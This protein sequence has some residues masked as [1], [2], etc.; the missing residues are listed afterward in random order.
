MKTA[1]K[2][3][4]IKSNTAQK[5]IKSEVMGSI[6]SGWHELYLPFKI[7]FLFKKKRTIMIINK[8]Y[9]YINKSP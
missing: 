9:I 8:R 7:I 4:Q 5:R 6:P 2:I 3:K 1:T